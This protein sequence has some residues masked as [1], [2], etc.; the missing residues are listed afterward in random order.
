MGF[1]FRTLVLFFVLLGSSYAEEEQ[2]FTGLLKPM[3]TT[4]PSDQPY[5]PSNATHTLDRDPKVTEW[6]NPAVCGDCHSPAGM[7]SQN[8]KFDET[9]GKHG[10]FTADVPADNGVSC[11]ACHII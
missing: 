6:G 9:L 10:N 5:A 1:L 4:S 8:I 3:E 2:L 11:D 7:L